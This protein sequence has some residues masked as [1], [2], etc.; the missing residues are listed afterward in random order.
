M[1]GI[2]SRASSDVEDKIA[3]Q[4]RFDGGR[5][6]Q[7][8]RLIGLDHVR[9]GAIRVGIDSNGGNAQ[10]AAGAQDAKGDFATVGDE[11]FAKHKVR[12]QGTAGAR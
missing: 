12:V 1:D 2:G 7:A 3:A 5:G 6:P 9:G 11:D 10:L 4:I 8:V